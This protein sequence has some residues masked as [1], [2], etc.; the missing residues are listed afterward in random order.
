VTEYKCNTKTKGHKI[1]LIS[2]V[3]HVMASLEMVNPTGLQILS[4][5]GW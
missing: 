2:L 1:Q 4:P 5:E 3:L